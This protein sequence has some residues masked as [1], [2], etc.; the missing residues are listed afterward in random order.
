MNYDLEERTAEFGEDVINDFMV[1][2]TIN[3]Q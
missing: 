2:I 1:L 3:F